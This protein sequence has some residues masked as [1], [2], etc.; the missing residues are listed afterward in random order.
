MGCVR[1]SGGYRRGPLELRRASHWPVMIT[2][3]RATISGKGPCIPAGQRSTFEVIRPLA[4]MTRTR[5][6]TI[7]YNK[8]AVTFV[9]DVWD[10]FDKIS[11]VIRGR[12]GLEVEDLFL[13]TMDEIADEL[14]FWCRRRHVNF[15]AVFDLA[16][17]T[18]HHVAWHANNKQ[19]A[20]VRRPNAPGGPMDHK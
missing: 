15:N 2:S 6:Y 20:K 13:A 16:T 5:R 8:A 9:C 12:I 4:P 14:R 3:I 1:P 11:T 17:N 18:Y 10:L 19:R 7:I